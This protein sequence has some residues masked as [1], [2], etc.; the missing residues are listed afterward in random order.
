MRVCH[1]NRPSL[2]PHF[3]EFA[4]FFGCGT[5]DLI[6]L[7]ETWLKSHVSDNFIQLQGCHIVR[8]DREGVGRRGGGVY[9]Q[10]GIEV[11][12]LALLPA[13]YCGQPE[14]LL[15][16][17][18]LSR[19]RPVLLGVVYRSPKLG[20]FSV[21]QLDLERY[22]PSFSAAIILGDFNIDL[23]RALHDADFLLDFS[24][25]NR[26]YLVLFANTHHITLSHF[27]INHSLVS[28]RDLVRSFQQP[29]FS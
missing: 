6:V 29:H 24:L 19:S 26:F 4:D 22:H 2:L 11:T 14:Y 20:H 13:L 7:S 8:N 1:V 21:F 25:S 16:K 17:I 9:V 18:S 12:V 10:D 27:R 3:S 23:N 28:E 5:F 15:L